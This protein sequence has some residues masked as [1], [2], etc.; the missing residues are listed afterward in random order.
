MPKKGE[1]KRGEAL[2]G[3][4]ECPPRLTFSWA[5]RGEVARAVRVLFYRHR[6]SQRDTEEGEVEGGE[7]LHRGSGGVPQPHFPLGRVA[8]GLRSLEQVRV[9]S[10][11]HRKS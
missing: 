6:K 8:E 11:R 4:L 9:L 3:G 10:Y 2:H 5:G 1:L 7:A